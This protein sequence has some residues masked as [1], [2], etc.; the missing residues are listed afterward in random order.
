MFATPII[1][2]QSWPNNIDIIYSSL[3]Q[4]KPNAKNKNEIN[5]GEE[6]QAH[7]LQMNKKEP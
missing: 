7:A 4:N 6:F 2:Y 3:N 5:F 1:G